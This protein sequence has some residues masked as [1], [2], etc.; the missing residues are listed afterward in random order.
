MFRTMSV[1]IP[2][3]V[4]ICR[5]MKNGEK[6]APSKAGQNYGDL[7]LVTSLLGR[8]RDPHDFSKLE[9]ASVSEVVL[10]SEKEDEY[11]SSPVCRLSVG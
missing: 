9:I 1:Y 3:D 10:V 5:Y 6:M 8:F 7:N 4:C 11:T 2:N